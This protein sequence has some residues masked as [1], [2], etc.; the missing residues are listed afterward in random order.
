MGKPEASSNGKWAGPSHAPQNVSFSALS[1][2]SPD[3]DDADED[4][5]SDQMDRR[6]A[7]LPVCPFYFDFLY[8]MPKSSSHFTTISRHVAIGGD[9]GLNGILRKSL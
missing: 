8:L 4:N 5:K 7:L 9:R 6:C 2:K 1:P 3:Y